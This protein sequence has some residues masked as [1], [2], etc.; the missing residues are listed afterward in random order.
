MLKAPAA[1]KLAGQKKR[2]TGSIPQESGA[3]EAEVEVWEGYARP[4]VRENEETRPA[5]MYSEYEQLLDRTGDSSKG[6]VGR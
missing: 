3:T 4:G 2:I 6:E 5:S 1:K